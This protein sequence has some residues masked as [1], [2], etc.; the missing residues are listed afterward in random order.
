MAL[1]FKGDALRQKQQATWAAGDY[2]KIAA[3]VTGEVEWLVERMDLDAGA[4]VLDVAAGTGNAALAAARR[5]AKVTACDFVPA[6]LDHAVKRAGAEGLEIVTE[7]A[8]CEALPFGDGVFDAAVSSFGIMFA[9]GHEKAASEIARVVRRG[10]RIGLANW[11]PQGFIGQLLK[12]VGRHLPPPPAGMQ[13]PVLWGDADHLRQLFPGAT[14]DIVERE[15]VFRF[16]SAEDWVAFF[17]AYY[18]PTNRAFAALD[19]AGAAALHEEI[20]ALLG[21]HNRA[22]R[23]LKVPSSYLD[24]IVTLDG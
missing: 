22:E 24:V 20:V 8:D 7:P 19:E 21:A 17:R 18:G 9:A 15:F 13:P 6:L 14:L 1:D 10:G 4:R 3:L 12:T 5:N 23:G 2:Q 11:T 16:A